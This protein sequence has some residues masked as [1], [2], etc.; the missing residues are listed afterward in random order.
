[1]IKENKGVFNHREL[2]GFK[3]AETCFVVKLIDYSI[4]STGEIEEHQF[5]SEKEMNEWLD[6]LFLGSDKFI[7]SV[8]KKII[9]QYNI[10]DTE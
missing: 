2:E 1:M 5:S 9:Y 3:E 8:E 10:P 7:H 4:N 6:R